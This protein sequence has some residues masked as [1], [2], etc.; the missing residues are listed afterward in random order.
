MN[1][2]FIAS[3]LTGALLAS[4]APVANAAVALDRTR[5]VYPGNEKS[6]SLSISNQNPK[7][8]YLAQAWLETEE[9]TKLT[10]SAPLMVLPP[11]QRVEPNGKGRSKFRQ[12]RVPLSCRRIVKRFFILTCA[13]F[14]RKQIKAM[15]CK[16]H[17]KRVSNFS[18][19]QRR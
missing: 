10:G 1:K 8:P 11:V 12:C 14:H 2:R 7:S 15:C 13:K 16:L 6:I 18:I 17:C 3:V 19:A 5:V 4:L 9:G